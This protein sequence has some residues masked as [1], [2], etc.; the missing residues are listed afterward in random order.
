MNKDIITKT[1]FDKLYNENITKREYDS[2]IKKIE[3][4]VK[5]RG[6]YVVTRLHVW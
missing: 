3:K 1:E 6:N 2:I 4:I 5:S